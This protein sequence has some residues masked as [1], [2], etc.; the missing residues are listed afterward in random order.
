MS[1][2][3]SAGLGRAPVRVDVW[4][5]AVSART[6]KNGKAEYVKRVLWRKVLNGKAAN[7]TAV[8][9][10]RGENSRSAANPL[11]PLTVF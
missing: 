2:G 11:K 8:D 10:R 5:E 3:V 7:A 1:P 9:A 4:P 6:A